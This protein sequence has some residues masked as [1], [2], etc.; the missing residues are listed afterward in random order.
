MYKVKLLF[1]CVYKILYKIGVSCFNFF[2]Y[3]DYKINFNSIVMILYFKF[4][5]FDLN[6]IGYGILLLDNECN[7]LVMYMYL[8]YVQG[9][10][11][12]CFFFYDIYRNNILLLL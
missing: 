11:I 10:F 8:M 1:L 4:F 3:Q 5:I 7:F 9:Y 12:W 6:K 2:L